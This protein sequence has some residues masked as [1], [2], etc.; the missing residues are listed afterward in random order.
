MIN[1]CHTHENVTN[2][3]IRKYGWADNV[4]SRHGREDNIK[5]DLKVNFN[6]I[7]MNQDRIQ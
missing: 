3:S 6:W 2:G 1:M 5:M 4:G 7:G